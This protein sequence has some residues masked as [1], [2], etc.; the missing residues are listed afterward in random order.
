MK[1]TIAALA[2]LLAATGSAFAEGENDLVYQAQLLT[3]TLS[4][5]DKEFCVAKTGATSGEAYD[6]CRVTRL[7]LADINASK[8]KGVPPLT[9]IKYAVDKVEK[10]KIMD[11]M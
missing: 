3:R 11:R 2:L 5:A 7:F 6:A 9:D 10:S 4:A 8:D 1:T